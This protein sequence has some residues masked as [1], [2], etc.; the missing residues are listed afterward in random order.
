MVSYAIVGASR[1]IGLEYVRQ[2]AAR[3]DAVVFPVVR[4]AA[5]SRYLQEAVAGLSN[6]HILEAEVTDY[7][8]LQASPQRAAS[9][10]S[11]KN[12][13]ALD[14]LIYS[15]C[16][17]EQS[18]MIKA[19][20]SYDGN[21][22]LLDDEF[23]SAYKVNALGF[24]H[25]V[26]A[27]LPLLRASTS[28]SGKRIVALGSAAADPH[29]IWNTKGAGAVAYSMTKAAQ[30]LAQTKWA[31]ELAGDGFIVVSLSPGVVDTADTFEG[32]G[33]WAAGRG[34]NVDSGYADLKTQKLDEGVA[35]QIKVI[36][37]LSA[38][39]NGKFLAHT[40]EDYKF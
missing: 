11:E 23:I 30:L 2:L 27:L 7:P 12:G 35:L 34:N 37:G 17:T 9:A 32:E 4:N 13:G 33:E 36:D 14:C 1:G 8:S 19:F 16:L 38:K 26:Q 40:G 28:A 25:A 15:A 18:V 21:M 22:D 10:I 31:L 29:F 3:P 5:N 24:I 20:A 6:V 39:D